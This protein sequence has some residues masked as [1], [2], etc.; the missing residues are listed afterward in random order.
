M[1]SVS[2]LTVTVWAVATGSS[3]TAVTFT[4]TEAAL[5][6]R[7]PDPSAVTIKVKLPCPLP[8]PF[9]AETYMTR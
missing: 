6:E 4:V 7:F 2:S 1:T 5:E 3:L 8:L 9:D